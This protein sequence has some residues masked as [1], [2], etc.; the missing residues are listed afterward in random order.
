MAI[1]L[2]KRQREL[3]RK[4]TLILPFGGDE[5][6]VYLVVGNQRFRLA[7][8]QQSQRNAKWMASC[9][10]T[11]LDNLIKMEGGK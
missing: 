11:E 1:K 7:Y 6:S 3:K 4:Y 2:T 8:Q 10:T 9:L 5:Y